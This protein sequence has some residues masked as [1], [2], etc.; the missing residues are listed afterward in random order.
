MRVKIIGAGSVGNHLAHSCRKFGLDVVL[1]DRDPKALERMQK[2]IYPTR[3]GKW[4]SQ[5]QLRSKADQDFWDLILI[6][7]PPDS[8]FPIANEIL[9]NKRSRGLFIEKPLGPPNLKEVFEFR[10]M[11]R[12]SD[13]KVFVGYNHVLT[14]NTL[15]F[16]STLKDNAL[17]KP[18][19]LNVFIKEHWKGIFAAHPWL[20]GPQDSYLGFSSRGGGAL[21]EHSHGISIFQ[22]FARIAGAGRIAEV[23]AV[24]S[25]V[26][27][28]DTHYDQ[29]AEL[30]IRT[31][32][33]MTGHIQQDV[34]TDPVLKRAHL[35][36]E[37]AQLEWM[38]NHRKGFDAVRYFVDDEQKL[39]EIEKTRPDDFHPEIEHLIA[40][41]SGKED[42]DKSPIHFEHG[43]DA[44]LVICAAFKSHESR[45]T[46]RINYESSTLEGLLL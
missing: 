6:A 35:Q 34:I 5:I 11:S 46:V 38:V 29:M 22:H 2:E 25:M 12:E 32:S 39:V 13:I 20:S 8:H 26:H 27:T 24:L 17:I 31:E 23:A 44:M 18:L 14:K 37:N 42:Y 16:E 3:Y 1:F 15:L 33:G 4:D 19:H 45:Q 43:V 7:T 41:L 9:K 30:N 28:K 21:C 10:E 40:V 36:Y